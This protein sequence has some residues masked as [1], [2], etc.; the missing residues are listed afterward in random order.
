MQTG[1]LVDLVYQVRAIDRRI[2]LAE[3]LPCHVDDLHAFAPGKQTNRCIG[4]ARHITV[5]ANYSLACDLTECRS[6]SEYR[7]QEQITHHI[8]PSKSN[9]SRIDKSRAENI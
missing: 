5:N 8:G 3:I 4:R 7:E 2:E 1:L 6:Q 9:T